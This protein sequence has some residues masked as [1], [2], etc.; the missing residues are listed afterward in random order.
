MH[1]NYKIFWRIDEVYYVKMKNVNF[2]YSR[3]WNCNLYAFFI[4]HDGLKWFLYQKQLGNSSRTGN[5][6]SKYSLASWRDIVKSPSEEKTTEDMKH[7]GKENCKEIFGEDKWYGEEKEKRWGRIGKTMYQMIGVDKRCFARI[8]RKETSGE[9]RFGWQ[10]STSVFRGLIFSLLQVSV[11][12]TRLKLLEIEGT[13]NFN[14]SC[15]RPHAHTWIR[16]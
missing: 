15:R 8:E 5:G 1:N 12:L 16:M 11:F 7:I 2:S 4:W 14:H 9:K 10:R 6:K 13:C 3:H